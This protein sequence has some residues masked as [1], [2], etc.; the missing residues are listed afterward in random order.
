[1]AWVPLAFVSGFIRGTHQHHSGILSFP[2]C[3]RTT[4]PSCS[5][6]T[7]GMAPH[8]LLLPP[9]NLPIPQRLILIFLIQRGRSLCSVLTSL[10]NP[11]PQVMA[12]LLAGTGSRLLLQLVVHPSV[13][14]LTGS[15][16]SGRPACSV[17]LSPLPQHLACGSSEK[18]VL[19][20]ALGSHDYDLFKILFFAPN[21]EKQEQFNL[22]LLLV[23]H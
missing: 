11:T 8:F 12:S 15:C 23:S 9:A 20:P 21:K 16:S 19:N 10:N 3:S 17:L 7:Q 22:F 2:A 13:P 1:M 14:T 5:F 4:Q 18:K 6:P